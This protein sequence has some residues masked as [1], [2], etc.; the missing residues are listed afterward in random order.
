MSGMFDLIRTNSTYKVQRDRID[1]HTDYDMLGMEDVKYMARVLG[2]AINPEAY[3][4]M[5][6][7][8]LQFFAMLQ[9]AF[10]GNM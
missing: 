9:G 4:Q 10:I 8:A 2:E 1:E 5:F 7:F 3:A 6:S